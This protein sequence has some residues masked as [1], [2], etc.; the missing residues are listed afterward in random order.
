M[1]ALMAEFPGRF[2]HITVPGGVSRCLRGTNVECSLRGAFIAPG[3]GTTSVEDVVNAIVARL[4]TAQP[5]S[6]ELVNEVYTGRT[7]VVPNRDVRMSIDGLKILVTTTGIVIVS[8]GKTGA[9][10]AKVL[11]VISMLKLPTEN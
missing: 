1:A 10:A 8:T 7:G 2:D 4:P 11:S 5:H 6:V 9:T 3:P